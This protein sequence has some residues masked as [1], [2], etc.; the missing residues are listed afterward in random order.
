[1][2]VDTGRGLLFVADRGNHRIVILDDTGRGRGAI[3]FASRDPR[4]SPGEPKCLAADARGRLFVVDELS[5]SVRV[6]TARGSRLAQIDLPFPTPRTRPRSVAV[7]ASGTVYVLYD[8]DRKGIVAYDERG[9]VRAGI[10]VDPDAG[11]FS[12][13]AAIAVRADESVL[14]VVDPLADRQVLL[15]TPEGKRLAAF[16]SHGDGDGTFSLA[17]HVTWGPENT[18]WITDTL[19]HSVNVFDAEGTYLGRV[20]GF[21]R[22]P[23]QFFYPVACGFAAD[24]NLVVLERGS[25]RLQVLDV[26]Y[27]RREEGTA[28]VRGP[29][30]ESP[31]TL[32]ATKGGNERC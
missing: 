4:D 24:G 11:M 2:L 13:P 14:A 27:S 6:L 20:G 19:R 17:N 21:G 3:S 7:G 1:M 22:G 8:G 18:L 5:T 32:R 25:G 26:G 10:G 29:L 30:P 31:P 9:R 28:K 16:G 23:G 15:L 12:S